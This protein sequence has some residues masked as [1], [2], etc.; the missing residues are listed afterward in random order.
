MLNEAKGNQLNQSETLSTTAP[1]IVNIVP[2][3]SNTLKIK[4]NESNVNF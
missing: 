3:A 1:S 2:S 4:K